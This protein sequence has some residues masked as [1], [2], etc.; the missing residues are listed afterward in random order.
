MNLPLLLMCGVSALGSC[1]FANTLVAQDIEMT[2]RMTGYT[3][4]SRYYDQVRRQP[5][6]FEIDRG[7]IAKARAAAGNRDAVA[8]TLPIVVVQAL[9]A[10]SDDPGFTPEEIHQSLF[11]GPSD[12][13]TV[14]DYYSEVS[15]G[16]F[17]VGGQVLPWTRTELTLSQTVG[18]SFGLGEDARTGDF[19]VQALSA[20][21]STVDFGLFD[22]D[23]ADGV[24]NSGDDD[25]FVDA[26]AFQF[27]EISASCGG[28]AIW[29]HRSR[30]SNW[31]GAPF[32]SNDGRPAGDSVMVNSYIIQSTVTCDGG[33]LATASTI[34]HELGHVLGLPD[35]YDR[36][37]GLLPEQRKWVVGC[38]S[39]MAAGGWGCGT[40]DRNEWKRPTHIGAWEKTRLGWVSERVLDHE[41]FGE[42]LLEPV[43]TS[44]TV[45]RIPLTATQSFLVEHRTQAGFDRDL[46]ASGVLIYHI[47]DDPVPAEC[48]TCPR[49]YRVALEEADGNGSLVRT[50]TEGGNR[51][52]AGDA[53][54]VFQP[55]TFSNVTSPSSRTN[56]GAP[57][58][59]TFHDIR[60]DG[61]VA[62]IFVSTATLV[63]DRL[64]QG[65]LGSSAAPLSDEEQRNLDRA[66]NANGRYDI[67]DLRTYLQH[68]PTV[69]DVSAL[70]TAK[71]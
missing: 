38:W 13:G 62:R 4:P 40:V 33:G 10:D 8:G 11:S 34:A 21:D 17:T 42:H 71:K 48:P 28:P 32:T 43:L 31:V 60:L 47:D 54:G 64:L 45:L 58:P 37:L 55:G 22:N 27:S 65:F 66:G 19:L 18:S 6:F 9:F 63:A 20:V 69:G 67:G 30:I 1:A 26:I 14:A 61:T 50:Q 2:S 44:A 56:D 70:S 23:G 53:W 25:G 15:G 52:E 3:L 46:P 39:L 36:S 59:V 35:L 51:G 41:P 7:W 24:P 16:V 29:P 68:N 49:T 5:A 12:N 57:T